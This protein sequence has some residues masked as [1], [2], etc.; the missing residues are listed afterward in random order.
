LR[1]VEARTSAYFNIC[2]DFI[3]E[4]NNKERCA[5][6]EAAKEYDD[7]GLL[8]WWWFDGWEQKHGPFKFLCTFISNSE[9]ALESVNSLLA[10]QKQPLICSI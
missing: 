10:S 2:S 9:K 4:P 3:F 6:F 8:P 1:E 7:K 5:L